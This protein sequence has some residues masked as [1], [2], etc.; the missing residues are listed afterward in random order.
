MLGGVDK[1]EIQPRLALS[2]E[3]E[4]NR[5]LLNSDEVSLVNES[6]WIKQ[7]RNGD[8]GVHAGAPIACPNAESDALGL[9]S[10]L[11]VVPSSLLAPIYTECCVPTSQL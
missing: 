11:A 7:R 10:G 5:I 3:D 2:L 6:P 4:G 1:A 8:P 9:I